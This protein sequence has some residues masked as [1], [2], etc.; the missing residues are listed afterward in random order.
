[1]RLERVEVS[2]L[3]TIAGAPLVVDL[4]HAATVLVGPNLCGKTNVARAL[5]LALDPTR[6]LGAADLPFGRS[7]AMPRVTCTFAGRERGRRLHRTHVVTWR[8]GA[9]RD[10]PSEPLATGAVIVSDSARTSDE[11]LAPVVAW[12]DVDAATLAADILPTFQRV[13][14]EV[15]AVELE[16]DPPHV[17]VRDRGGWPVPDRVVRATLGAALAAH[18]VRRGSDITA[19]VVEEPEAF[20]HPS[21]QEALRDELVE[22]AVAADAPVLLTTSSP[23]AVPRTA[24]CEVVALARDLDGT[25]R[26]VGR[27]AGDQAQAR[28]LGGLFRDAGLAMVLDRV[29]AV[30]AGVEAVLVVEG[31]TDQ[32]YLE[33]AADA[34]GRRDEVDRLAIHSCG[35]ALPAALHA[36]VMRAE[37]DVPVFVLLDNDTTGRMMKRT[38]VDRF[39]FTNRR[40][41]TTY[42]ECLPDHPEGTEAED[43][44]DWR[45]VARFV[46]EWGPRAVSGKHRLV[47]DHWHHDLV[48]AAKS[49]FV[50]WAREHATPDDLAGWARLLDVV[51]DRVL[52][53][54]EG[55]GS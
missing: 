30:P 31:G 1:M 13:L 26:V 32:A 9:R 36:I 46:E 20:L 25:T 27:A 42:A 18:L 5:L 44:F 19:I 28:L 6:T 41:V 43:L 37:T 15:A 50:G 53:L 3:R 49:A 24:E 7:D 21:A 23:F 52:T 14:P 40:E 33:I 10:E 38:L 47:D 39:G 54:R 29:A 16:L 45:F 35:G 2:D 51:A 55:N 34:L 22:V 48:T 4:G 12:L 11:V 17:V 8:D